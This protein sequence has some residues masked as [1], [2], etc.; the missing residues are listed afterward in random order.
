ESSKVSSLAWR[1]VIRTPRSVLVCCRD[2]EVPCVILRIVACECKARCT[3]ICSGRQIFCRQGR[4]V[5]RGTEVAAKD[6]RVVAHWCAVRH[7]IERQRR[8]S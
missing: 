3:C 5:T 2:T 8:D 6:R 4:E 7:M 1:D